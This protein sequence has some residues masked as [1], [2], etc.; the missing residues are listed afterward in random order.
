M[1]RL[2]TMVA[3]AL[4]VSGASAQEVMKKLSDGTY[5][6]NTTTLAD[7]VNGFKG[8]TP[9]E[10]HIKKDVIVKVV[11]LKNMETPKVFTKVNKE[12]LVKYEGLSVKKFA[13][14]KVDGVTG[15]SYSSDAI[16]ENVNRGVDYY[17]KNKKK[18]K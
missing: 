10:I 16:K 15:A 3:L 14:T 18:V 5:V 1:K 8:K 11:P 4:V 17:L 7:D 2:L 13:Q 12:L 6:V 9:V